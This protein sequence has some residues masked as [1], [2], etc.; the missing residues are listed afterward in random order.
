[1]TE[2]AALALVATPPT[3]PSTISLEDLLKRIWSGWQRAT[4]DII[5][6]GKACRQ[7]NDTWSPEEHQGLFKG[8]TLPFNRS[9]FTK[10]TQIRRDKRLDGIKANLPPSYSIIYEVTLLND[11]QLEDAL[12]DGII[13]PQVRRTEIV[14]LR[15]PTVDQGGAGSQDGGQE[16]QGDRAV[17]GENTAVQIEAGHLYELKIPSTVKGEDCDSISQ[18]L[19]KLIARF[20][21]EVVPINELPETANE[22]AVATTVPAI[23]S[24][25]HFESVCSPETL[26]H[27]A[28]QRSILSLQSNSS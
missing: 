1:M 11:A 24:E 25:P 8:K 6:V 13:H 23:H 12:R 20:G 4:V 15:K 18:A 7:I 17:S 28:V 14:A 10:L 2:T 22:F 19:E 3:E 5:E 16:S 21:V 27:R 9:T 26:H